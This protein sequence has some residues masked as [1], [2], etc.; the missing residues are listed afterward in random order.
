VKYYTFEVT[1]RGTFPF[2]MLRYDAAF[3]E[4]GSAVQQLSS[5][6][7][8]TKWHTARTIRLGS[9]RVTEPTIGR[10]NS[11]GWLVSNIQK[12]SLR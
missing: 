11:F 7:P 3:P 2:D 9:Y 10:W 8:S 5:E 6:Y 12:H 4:D 1:G